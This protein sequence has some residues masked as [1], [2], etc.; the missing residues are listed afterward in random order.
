MKWFVN[1]CRMVS[2][3]GVLICGYNAAACSI[4]VRM[5]DSVPLN[6]WDI[7]A[8]DRLKIANMV[9][10][11]RQWPDVQI[12]GIIYA[13][14]YVGE[15]N[16]EALSNKRANAIESYLMLLGLKKENI[17]KDTRLIKKQDA[18]H[19]GRLSI[20]QI[21]I[22]LVPICENGCDRLCNDPRV[23]PN[24]KALGDKVRQ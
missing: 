2:F 22:T 3:I 6:T 20:E 13:G 18:F 17:W 12:R 14:A 15:M 23:T 9:I 1:W 24:S 5:S 4:S 11:A 10:E 16:P 21:G 19:N 8:E 7:S